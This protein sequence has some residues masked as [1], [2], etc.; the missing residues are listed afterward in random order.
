MV[1]GSQGTQKPVM[2]HA[3][4]PLSFGPLAEEVE[5]LCETL[6]EK[7]IVAAIEPSEYY[8]ADVVEVGLSQGML[9]NVKCHHI[10]QASDNILSAAVR[11]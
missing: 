3:V 5:R 1:Q 6:Q 4:H 11:L 9:S 7:L 10:E 2:P 8:I